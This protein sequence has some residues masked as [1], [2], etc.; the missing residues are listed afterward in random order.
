M[1]GVWGLFVQPI[2]MVILGMVYGIGFT[3]LP[4][5]NFDSNS[6]KDHDLNMPCGKLNDTPRAGFDPGMNPFF[7]P[8]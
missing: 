8:F 5:Y 1:T 7:C 6:S 2:K 4:Q 3:S